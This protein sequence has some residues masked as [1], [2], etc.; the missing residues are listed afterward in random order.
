MNPLCG[1]NLSSPCEKAKVDR[2]NIEIKN[3]FFMEFPFL[4]I[5]H[6]GI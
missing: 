1:P 4:N 6:I 2:I 3:V 5:P